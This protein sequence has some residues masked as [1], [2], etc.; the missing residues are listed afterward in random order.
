MLLVDFARG[1]RVNLAS[2]NGPANVRRGSSLCLLSLKTALSNGH[3]AVESLN[4]LTDNALAR[5]H[6]TSLS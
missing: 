5:A 3:Q 6:A 2:G 1:V 4:R